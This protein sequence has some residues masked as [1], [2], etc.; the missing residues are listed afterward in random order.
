MRLTRIGLPR[1]KIQENMTG[2]HGE[3]LPGRLYLNDC[4]NGAGLGIRRIE[5]SGIIPHGHPIL[6]GSEHVARIDHARD[7]PVSGSFIQGAAPFYSLA[8]ASG[9]ERPIPMPAPPHSSAI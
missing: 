8:C 9:N 7:R 6:G 5:T 3:Q 1:H 4:A 2:G